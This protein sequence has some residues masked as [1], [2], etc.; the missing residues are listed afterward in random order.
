MFDLPPQHPSQSPL[1]RSQPGRREAAPAR[2]LRP[3]R[4][5]EENIE[6][7][8]TAEIMPYPRPLRLA[9]QSNVESMGESFP[10][11]DVQA[12]VR[13]WEAQYAPPA[14]Q[15]VLAVV[16]YPSGPVVQ[17]Q[18]LRW[19]AVEIIL[20]SAEEWPAQAHPP[21]ESPELLRQVDDLAQQA[22]RRG[23]E[24]A[25]RGRTWYSL[26]FR[27]RYTCLEDLLRWK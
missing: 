18:P 17:W 4:H 22:Q 15:F 11:G 19:G 27:Q 10:A 7:W 16:E 14:A 23:W 1:H 3:R 2:P 5:P 24:P 13:F 26:R 12:L 9:H 6:G 8:V 20:R 25:G 21:L